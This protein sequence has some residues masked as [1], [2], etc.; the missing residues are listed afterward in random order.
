MELLSQE[1][2][3]YYRAFESMFGSIGWK[4]FTDEI[5]EG[6]E[7]APERHFWE[8]KSLED[9]KAARAAHSQLVWLLNYPHHIEAKK[10]NDIAQAEF[11]AEQDAEEQSTRDSILV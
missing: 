1:Q 7:N 8:A 2:Q 9:L 5:R 6:M 3:E 11:E 10:Q 4:L